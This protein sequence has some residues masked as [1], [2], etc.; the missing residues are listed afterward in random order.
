MARASSA[1]VAKQVNG[2]T[3][4]ANVRFRTTWLLAAKLLADAS[5]PQGLKLTLR[6]WRRP[7][8]Q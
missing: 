3:A 7:L 2:W 5:Y 6:H 1:M 8:H 4:K